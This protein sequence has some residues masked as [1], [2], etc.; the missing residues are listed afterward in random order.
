MKIQEVIDQLTQD[1]QEIL[2]PEMEFVY[3]GTPVDPED[4]DFNQEGFEALKRGV[5]DLAFAFGG[6][7]GFGF[8]VTENPRLARSNY[9]GRSGYVFKYRLNPA[10]VLDLRLS[11]HFDIWK[12]SGLDRMTGDRR[13]PAMA[14]RK[15]I[16]GV[17]DRSVGGI[18][19]YNPKAL[20]LVDYE[21][22]LASKS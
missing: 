3:H 20:T 5:V 19:I 9:A 18:C 11:E 12:R 13:M 7:F 15:G 21:G 14:V 10:R 2:V 8:Y 4:P 1:Q 16:D 22:P 6:Y 17:Y